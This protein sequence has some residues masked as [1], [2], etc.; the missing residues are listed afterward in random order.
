M[1]R[2]LFNITEDLLA[3]ERI[4]FETGGDI[5]DPAVSEVV[6]QWFDELQGDLNSKVENYCSLIKD[7]EIRAS[8]RKRE[9][10]RIRRLR[11]VDENI[12]KSL[13]TRMQQ[14]LDV[15]QIPRVN[16]GL[17]RVTVANNGGKQPMVL[18]ET[19]VPA[20][21]MATR[22][23]TEVNK[24]LVRSHLEAGDDLP[25]AQLKERGRS[26]RIA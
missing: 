21:Y 23:V 25:F 2:S 14:A 20:E 7:I 22:I 3:L 9:E 16:T 13:K 17:F 6:D 5:T 8:N 10:E 19:N 26:L 18:D 24:D 15:L 11:Q 12:V 1:S 4:L